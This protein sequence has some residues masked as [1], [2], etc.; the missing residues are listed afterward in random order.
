MAKTT[1]N[2]E[3]IIKIKGDIQL[4]HQKLDNHITHISSKIDTIFKIVWTV[5]FMVLGL[6]LKAVYSG[7]LN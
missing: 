5:S 3:D 1:Q 6:I 2:R 4:I 7:L